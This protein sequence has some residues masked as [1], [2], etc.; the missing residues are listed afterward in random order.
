MSFVS[1][2]STIL[3]LVWPFLCVGCNSV[4]NCT[5]CGVRRVDVDYAL[6]SAD[7][8]TSLGKLGALFGLGQG[9]IKTVDNAQGNFI[10]VEI[11]LNRNWMDQEGMLQGL[12][13]VVSSSRVD[14]DIQS[15]S[16]THLRAH[17]T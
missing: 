13:A 1:R 10:L 12:N 7:A 15:V 17:E 3:V 6:P 8:T 14:L 5:L 2:Y 9:A 11:E 4:T 16:Y